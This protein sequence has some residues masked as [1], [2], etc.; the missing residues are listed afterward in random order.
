MNLY[1]NFF[2]KVSRVREELLRDGW[3]VMALAETGTFVKWKEKKKEMEDEGW[4]AVPL[5]E[6]FRATIVPDIRVHEALF[7]RNSRPVNVMKL[8]G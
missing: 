6:C 8:A 2:A 3:E 1:A 5:C 7:K 4:I